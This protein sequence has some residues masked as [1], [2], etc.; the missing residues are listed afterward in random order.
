MLGAQVQNLTVIL[1]MFF[2]FQAE[3]G[4][5]DYK[6]TGVQTRALPIL[7]YAAR[8]AAPRR[9]SRHRR[10]RRGRHRSAARSVREDVLRAAAAGP[11]QLRPGREYGAVVGRRG[12]A[13]D[14]GGGAPEKMELRAGARWGA[15]TAGLVLGCWGGPALAPEP[16]L[17]G[18]PLAPYGGAVFVPGGGKRGS[19]LLVVGTGLSPTRPHQGL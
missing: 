10:A 19:A 18:V 8:R 4:I 6:V 14:R 15:L 9:G 2:F 3:D 12:G 1:M 13:A 5:R 11:R 17:A 7:A 16:P